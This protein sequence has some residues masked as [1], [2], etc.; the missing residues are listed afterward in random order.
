MKFHRL[1]AA[2]H[3]EYRVV[4]GLALRRNSRFSSYLFERTSTPETAF[5]AVLKEHLS[6]LTALCAMR[7]ETRNDRFVGRGTFRSHAAVRNPMPSANI[8]AQWRTIL[9]SIVLLIARCRD[10][11]EDAVNGDSEI[12]SGGKCLYNN[13]NVAS[14]K[15][16]LPGTCRR[17]P[18]RRVQSCVEEAPLAGNK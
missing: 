13:Q 10:H 7:G 5:D 17:F 2:D 14:S 9:T 8:R 6:E 18:D 11:I 16:A 3:L 12:R 4:F 15:V 1:I